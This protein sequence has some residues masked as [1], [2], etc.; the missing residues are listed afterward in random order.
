MSVNQ[1]SF[2]TGDT[3]ALT[4][5]VIPGSTPITAD[6][7][8]ALQVPGCT[9]LA[10]SLYWQGDLNFTAAPQPY[11]SNWPISAFSGPI[12]SYTFSGTEQ[13]GSYDWPGAFTVPGTGNILRGIMQA[14]FTFNP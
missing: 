8:I 13:A 6:I 14:P 2:R 7:Y 1:S 3:L 12:F 9:S 5:R 11:V 10:C 4:A